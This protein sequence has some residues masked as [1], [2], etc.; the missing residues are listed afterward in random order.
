[1]RECRLT[2]RDDDTMNRGMPVRGAVDLA[3]LA[4]ANK[5][6][7]EAEARAASGPA[8]PSG[9]VID[10]TEATF[11]T[12]VI[13]RSFQ[14]PVIVDLWATW[15]GP[16]KT[17]SPILEKLTLEYAGRLALAKIDV[18]AEQS[19]GAAFQVQSIPAIFA[20]IKGQ[21]VEL[22]AGAVPEPQVREVF[23]KV[24][25]A[26][27]ANGMTGQVEAIAAA[28]ELAA[29]SESDDGLGGGFDIAVDAIDRGDW[30]GAE[31]AFREILT[32]SPLDAMATA[33]LAQVALL[34]RTDGLDVAAAMARATS[35]DDVDAALLV[36]DVEVLD[37]LV[38]EAFARLI[39]AVRTTSGPDR[40][41]VR[42]RLLELFEVIGNGDPRVLKART[43]LASAL[44]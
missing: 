21:P 22:F 27:E 4:E 5:A 39:D 23:E 8:V 30:D 40:D 7:Q 28:S 2:M 12:E 24:L 1:M 3:A 10:V 43:A 41:R 13:D 37:G 25:A 17:L 32:A 9:L 26:A 38:D 15:C 34:R 44:F 18:D 33:G 6:R 31:A 29:E 16:C 11:Q 42:A 14:V 19:L 35:P 20:V 36:S